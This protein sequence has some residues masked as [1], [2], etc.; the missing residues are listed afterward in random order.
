MIK[1]DERIIPKE[2]QTELPRN[3]ISKI[4]TI[5]QAEN[6]DNVSN[7][8]Y[9]IIIPFMKKNKMSLIAISLTYF[10]STLIVIFNAIIFYFLSEKFYSK[11]KEEV[12]LI[13]QILFGVYVGL[14]LFG[15]LFK[16]F[17]K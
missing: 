10:F 6:S 5:S 17:Q 8:S 3:P 4:P 15:S 12:I 11:N 9:N 16:T 1:S 2:I 14:G 13:G 7:F